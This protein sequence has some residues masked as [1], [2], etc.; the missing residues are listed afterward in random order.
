MNGKKIMCVIFICIFLCGI[1]WGFYYT[2]S[3]I[4]RINQYTEELEKRN[5]ELVEISERATNR[6][7]ELENEI[8]TITNRFRKMADGL[9]HDNE[10]LSN[11]VKRFRESGEIIYGAYE[12]NDSIE[13]SIKRLSEFVERNGKLLQKAVEY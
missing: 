6:A 9:Q 10:R 1:V 7:A 3:R 13:Q 4:Y 5:T 2:G 12:R 11:L 8:S